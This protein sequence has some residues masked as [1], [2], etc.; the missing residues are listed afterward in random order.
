M[1][2]ISVQFV[3]EVSDIEILQ[4]ACSIFDSMIFGYALTFRTSKITSVLMDRVGVEIFEASFFQEV[5]G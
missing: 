2:V 4:E 3:E 1:C 5:K